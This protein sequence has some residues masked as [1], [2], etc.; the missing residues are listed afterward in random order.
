VN[1]F[2]AQGFA[3]KLMGILDSSNPHNPIQYALPLDGQLINL[4]NLIGQ[5]II[6]EHVETIRCVAC[7]RIIS[8]SF[9]QGYCF[10]CTQ[11]LAQ[12]DLCI[13]KPERCHYHLGTCREPQWGEA[14]C[15]QNH[16]VY[17]ANTSGLKVGITREKNIPSRWIDQGAS[18]ALPIFKVPNRLI[19]GKIEIILAQ[20]VKDKTDWRKM[21]K[22][23]GENLN[24]IELKN[25][26][27]N[28]AELELKTQGFLDFLLGPEKEEEKE[29]EKEIKINYPVLNYP[30]KITSLN[31]LK[32]PRLESTLLGIKGQ[33]LIL[34]AGVLNSRSLAG[35][36][37]SLKQRC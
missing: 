7:H 28:Q 3:E 32:T 22:G 35:L 34:E 24:L 4:N 23:P 1:N 10:P 37:V 15:L 26:L 14:H 30:E 13:V 2:L 29:K 11:K 31:L 5:K 16:M 27:L 25:N 9:Q 12:C 8:K 36:L 33:Y 18:Q 20:Y 6:L 19:S 17:L 21:L